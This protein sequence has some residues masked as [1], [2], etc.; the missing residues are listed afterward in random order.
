MRVPQRE[1]AA[2]YKA[3]SVG[4]AWQAR[5]LHE[6]LDGPTRVEECGGERNGRRE[7]RA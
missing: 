3:W 6:D 1:A 5:A 2:A 7:E 4:S